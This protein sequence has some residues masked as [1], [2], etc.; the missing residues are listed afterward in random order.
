MTPRL[1]H[2]VDRAAWA[3]A[4]ERG[5]YRAASL[6]T[7]GFIH[8]SY[9]DQVERTANLRFAGVDGLCVVELDAARI[10][11]RIEVED[12]YGSGAAFPHV[13]GPI[14]TSAAVAI[15]DLVPAN[16]GGWT[17]TADG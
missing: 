12:S 14:P 9:A 8:C 2:I 16:H 13:Y 10:P 15:H 4:V 5:E 1:F 7:E 6:A 11:A 17:F 3:G